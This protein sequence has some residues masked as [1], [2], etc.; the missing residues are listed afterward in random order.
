MK[1]NIREATIYIID[2]VD[3]LIYKIVPAAGSIDVIE[4]KINVLRLIFGY[5]DVPST[6]TS[7]ISITAIADFC[8]KLNFAS[9]VMIPKNPNGGYNLSPV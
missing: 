2:D 1:K 7:E 8:N 9:Y 4:V 6:N 5:T 3:N